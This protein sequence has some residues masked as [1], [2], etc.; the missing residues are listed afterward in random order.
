MIQTLVK[1]GILLCAVTFLYCAPAH[2]LDAD[3][4]RQLARNNNCA[5]CHDPG[6]DKDGPEFKKIAEKYKGDGQV[7]AKLVKH[8]TSGNPVEFPDGHK[9][10]HTIVKTKPARDEAQIKNLVQ[11]VLSQ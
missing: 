10:D 1:R 8:L 3:A 7:E 4:A 11:W 2:A 5:K 9:E 6:P